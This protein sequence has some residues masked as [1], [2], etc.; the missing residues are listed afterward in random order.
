MQKKEILL[1]NEFL[2]A[3][4][5]P[6][7]GGILTKFAFKKDSQLIDIFRPAKEVSL[8]EAGFFLMAPY[9]ARLPGLIAQWPKGNKLK[10]AHPGTA[11]KEA[12]D[13]G[14]HGIVRY[15]PFQVLNQS[16]NQ[17]QLEQNFKN[18]DSGYTWFGDFQTRLDFVLDINKLLVKINFKN[19]AKI[20]MPFA[21]GSHPKFIKSKQKAKVQFVTEG[22]FVPDMT[23]LVPTKEKQRIVPGDNFSRDNISE[24]EDSWDHCRYGWKG[25]ASVFWEDL[26]IKL[27][28][29]REDSN[30]NFLQCWGGPGRDDQ[31]AL[32]QQT[33]AANAIELYHQGVDN[34]NLIILKPGEEVEL[35]H[36]YLV[37]SY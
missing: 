16:T 15:L 4:V 14:I 28:I 27:E 11:S 7:I 26:K 34:L 37:S 24:M 13:R 8:S 35:I 5:C 17:L 22:V 18:G 21:A 31:W 20:E 3:K 10:I 1:E 36:T 6:E 30:S 2:Q 29:D 19:T 9:I 33:S 25:K 12:R 23:A 32:E